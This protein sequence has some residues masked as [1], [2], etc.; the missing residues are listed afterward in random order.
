[1]TVQDNVPP[2][3]AQRPAWLRPRR[4]P[5]LTPLHLAG[6]AVAGLVALPVVYLVVRTFSGDS[7]A[8]DLIFR[9]RTAEILFRSVLLVA[10][11]T[12]GS[13]AI[14]VPMAWLT[15][16]TDLPLKRFWAVTSVLP[17]VIPSFIAGFV[18]VVALG[19]RGMLQGLLNTLFGVDRIP[20]MFG[21]PGASFVLILLTFPYVLIPVRASLRRMDPAMEEMARGLGRGS[22][23][24]FASITLP[25][26]RPAIAAGGLLSALYTLSD[27]GAVSILRYETFTWAVFLQYESAFD[28]AIAAALSLVLVAVALGILAVDVATRGRGRY[29]RTTVGTARPPGPVNLGRWRW[30]AFGFVASVVGLS[31]AAPLAILVFWAVRGVARGEDVGIDSGTVFNSLQASG[32]AAVFTTIAAI[33]VAILAVRHRSL[34]STAIELITHLGFALPGIAVALALVFFGVNVFT[35]IYQTRTLLV[36]AYV[37]LF[38]PAAA[39]AIKASLMQVNPRIEEAARGLGKG[40]WRV[41]YRI[42]FPLVLPGILAGAATVFLLTMKELPATLI[43]GPIGFKT[44]S[45]QIWGFTTE[46]FFAKAAVPALVLVIASGIPAAFL[47]LRDTSAR[48]G[49]PAAAETTASDPGNLP[50]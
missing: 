22:V 32:F 15:L 42:T 35:P 41:T 4:A 21:L 29:H 25:L 11:V 19:P 34:L 5:R 38:L 3:A 27:F 45:T 20:D 14:A 39:G 48:S 46:A 10:I 1:M 30:P 33:P 28:R 36:V 47:L 37:V 7:S 24:A 40:P 49:H 26:L 8:A 6:I 50:R 13:I 2:I 31:L 16:R 17:L 18:F 43:L 9:M 12:A 23:R 44:L